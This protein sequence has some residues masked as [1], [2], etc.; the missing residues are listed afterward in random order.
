MRTDPEQAIPFPL[1]LAPLA[2]FLV[3]LAAKEI[4]QRGGTRSAMRDLPELQ[5]ILRARGGIRTRNPGAHH[6]TAVTGRR[7]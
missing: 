5:A 3:E 7:S 1:R 4:T 6:G 2:A